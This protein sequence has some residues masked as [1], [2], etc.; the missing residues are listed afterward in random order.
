M[1][2]LPEVSGGLSKHIVSLR[3]CN[4]DSYYKPVWVRDLK[5][6]LVSL[7]DIRINGPYLGA[8]KNLLAVIYDKVSNYF[9][10]ECD[11]VFFLIS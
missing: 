5:E 3:I 7:H 1:L 6:I 8:S 10:P 11:L 9:C 2:M 4:G